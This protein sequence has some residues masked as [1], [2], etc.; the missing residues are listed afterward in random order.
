[1]N[2]EIKFRAWDKKQ[3]R[4]VVVQAPMEG[5]TAPRKFRRLARYAVH[6]TAR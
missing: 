2:R 3:Q 1:M 5:G 6:G 4:M